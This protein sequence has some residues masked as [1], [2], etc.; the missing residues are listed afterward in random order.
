MIIAIY[1]AVVLSY[2]RPSLTRS[3]LGY[4]RKGYGSFSE[5]FPICVNEAMQLMILLEHSTSF[6]YA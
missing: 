1:M 6:H 3:V 2:V 4:L 5:G